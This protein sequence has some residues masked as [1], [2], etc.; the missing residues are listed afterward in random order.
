[1]DKLQLLRLI[2]R[3]PDD[4]TEISIP[5][6]NSSEL[7]FN[8]DAITKDNADQVGASPAQRG[9]Y[10]GLK[11]RWRIQDLFKKSMVQPSALNP[12]DSTFVGTTI[13]LEDIPS[14]DTTNR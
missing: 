9:T 3:L 1:M 2:E 11:K 5:Q 12:I 13:D 14:A 6:H 7:L 8:S 4:A 10:H